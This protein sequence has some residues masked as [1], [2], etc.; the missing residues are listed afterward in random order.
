MRQYRWAAVLAVPLLAGCMSNA[1]VAL[2]SAASSMAAPTPIPSSTLSSSPNRGALTQDEVDKYVLDRIC[3]WG[4]EVVTR[5]GYSTLEPSA[6]CEAHAEGQVKKENSNRPSW[7]TSSSG[8]CGDFRGEGPYDF[9]LSDGTTR[10]EYG[11][12]CREA[13]RQAKRSLPPGVFVIEVIPL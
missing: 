10:Q 1:P 9:N 3:R 12:T 8:T 7:K 5:G 13:L 4:M 2:P 11:L 6:A